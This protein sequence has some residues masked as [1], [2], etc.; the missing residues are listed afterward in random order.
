VSL[1]VSCGVVWCRTGGGLAEVAGVG[2]EV[3]ADKV[4][5]VAEGEREGEVEGARPVGTAA[6]RPLL[7]G[8]THRVVLEPTDRTCRH[9]HTIAPR[10]RLHA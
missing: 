2:E 9:T 8:G 3:S 4:G 10:V 6:E 1:V 7:V 5:H